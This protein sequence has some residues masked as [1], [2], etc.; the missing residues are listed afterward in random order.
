MKGPITTEFLE[1]SATVNSISFVNSVSKIHPIYF[2]SIY[3]HG[4]EPKLGIS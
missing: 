2:I 3:I 1:K 4:V